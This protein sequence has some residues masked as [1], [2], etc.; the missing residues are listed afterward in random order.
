VYRERFLRRLRRKALRKAIEHPGRIDAAAVRRSTTFSEYDGLVT[1]PLHGFGSAE[2]YWTRSS[3]AR[4]V[5]GVRKPLL[6]LSA[7]DDPLVPSVS[8]PAEAAGQNPAVTLEVTS[9]GGHVAF[10]SG[11]P[12]SP[13]YWAEEQAVEYLVRHLD[14][15]L[16]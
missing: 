15:A 16:P 10:V 6:L 13:G 7:D 3:A 12:W 2:D 4:F 9:G 14:D 1:A 8:L 11:P 5:S